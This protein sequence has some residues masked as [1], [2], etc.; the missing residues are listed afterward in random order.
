MIAECTKSPSNKIEDYM[1]EARIVAANMTDIDLVG[2]LLMPH[3][4]MVDG[5]T[6]YIELFQK[7]RVG[8]LLLD[9]SVTN[10]VGNPARY[11]RTLTDKIKQA[12][13]QLQ[14][15]TGLNADPLLG[16][17]QEFGVVTRVR[18]GIA[19][20]PS[21]MALGAIHEPMLVERGWL[22][23]GEDLAGL[24]FNMDFGTDADVLSNEKNPVIVSR[25]FGDSVKAVADNVMASVR[26]LQKFGVA[27]VLK[28]FP[29]HGN[30]SSDSHSSLP[31]LSQSLEELKNT[32][33]PPF[34][35]GIRAGAWGVMNGHLDVRAID[36]GMPATFS[37]KISGDLLHSGMSFQGVA[38]T[39]AMGMAPAQKWDFGEAAVRAVLAGNDI[40]LKT[41]D[42]AKA[43]A[44]LLEA[45]RSGRL[46]RKVLEDRATKVISLRLLLSSFPQPGLEK[47]NT[48]EKQ[49]FVRS[50]QRMAVTVLKGLCDK[51]MI[52]SPVF[53]SG[54]LGNY[55][56]QTSRMKAN[57]AAL[58]YIV[59]EKREEALSHIHLVGYSQ[60]ED[61]LDDRATVTV[62][63]D[64]PFILGKAKS[65]Y[66]VAT[67]N[68]WPDAID[69]A[70]DVITGRRNA[71]G[72]SP[73]KVEGLPR[74]ACVKKTHLLF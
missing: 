61:A 56:D 5:T 70:T 44:G 8:G 30:T 34:Q 73:V 60:G 25:S 45:L 53:V 32:D 9:G 33:L 65:P 27:A 21:A 42:V 71:K 58:G 68:S 28:H 26:G 14:K 52:T 35:A 39:D 29:G 31:V 66:R 23:A 13:R 3:F 1:S 48:N 7:Y 20:L 12:A 46:P 72:I 17:D 54:G 64:T 59:T 15:E 2:Q 55:A 19:I 41:P 62:A 57:L 11:V 40:L 18:A 36:P 63:M 49:Q 74:S 38:V 24:G 6:N 22:Y 69:A 43:Q 67:Y 51:A 4:S 47:V 10:S 50:L 37:S 16:I